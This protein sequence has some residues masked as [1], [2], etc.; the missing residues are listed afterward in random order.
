[1]YVLCLKFPTIL[2]AISLDQTNL[3][4]YFAGYFMD[5]FQWTTGY[6]EQFGLYHVEFGKRER[7]QKASARFYSHVI[8]H[9]GLNW[10]YPPHFASE[11]K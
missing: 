11:G 1:M 2:S 4:G 3:A 7:M 6:S 9:K 8:K 10:N 5:S